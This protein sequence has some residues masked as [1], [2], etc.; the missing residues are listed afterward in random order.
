MLLPPLFGLTIQG[1]IIVSNIFEMLI[2]SFF[3]NR[4]CFEQG[5]FNFSTN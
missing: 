1:I 5:I 4:T 2:L 3:F